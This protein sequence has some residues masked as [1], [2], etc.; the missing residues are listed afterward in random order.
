[1]AH[2]S[3]IACEAFMP[4][5]PP[6]FRP[7]GRS[8]QQAEREQDRDRGSARARGYDGRWDKARAVHLKRHALC[9]YCE[10]EGRISGATLVDHLYPHNGDQT[11]FWCTEL[12]VSSCKPCHD[13]FK[14]A[15]EREGRA[16]LDI[17]ARRLGL[18]TLTDLQ[19]PRGGSQK[20]IRSG[21]RTGG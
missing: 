2:A 20:S 17:L 12:W 18:P 13:G 19:S 10:L 4:T 5:M 3:V 6:V 15:L 16:A 14:Q 8:A 9:R 1:M 7:H 21:A 11:L